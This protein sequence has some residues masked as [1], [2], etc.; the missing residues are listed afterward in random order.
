VA[1]PGDRA[2]PVDI[3]AVADLIPAARSA[4]TA[5]ARDGRSF[6]RDALAN[7]LR[8]DG[9]ELSNARASLVLKILKAQDD[10]TGT[11]RPG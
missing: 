9:H 5:L 6:S 7:A 10:L 8:D 3:R 4:R 11:E 1:V 2:A